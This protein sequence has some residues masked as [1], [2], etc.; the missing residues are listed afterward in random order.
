MQH[1]TDE[2]ICQMLTDLASLCQTSRDADAVAQIVRRLHRTHQ[3]SIARCFMAIVRVLA[4]AYD[5]RHYDLRNE[6]ACIM[7]FSI[8]DHI[9]E[10][11]LPFI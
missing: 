1:K 2:E 9:D 11:V 4:Q 3:Q 7:C 5:D 8:K 10:H 6:N